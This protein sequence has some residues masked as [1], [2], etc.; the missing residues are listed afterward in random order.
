MHKT[1]FFFFL[2][3][4]RLQLHVSD[5]KRHSNGDTFACDTQ[6]DKPVS[7]WIFFFGVYFIRLTMKC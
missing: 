7:A 2:V 6:I 4:T 3:Q 1:L 5:R